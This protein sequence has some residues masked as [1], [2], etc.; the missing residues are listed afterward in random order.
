MCFGLQTRTF[1][2]MPSL[3]V[4]KN[5]TTL[6]LRQRLGPIQCSDII[7]TVQD[8]LEVELMHTFFYRNVPYGPDLFN[9]QPVNN[10]NLPE[11]LV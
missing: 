1:D 8:D 10:K 6:D 2:P 4:V 11:G 9:G 5:Q 3:G 7:R